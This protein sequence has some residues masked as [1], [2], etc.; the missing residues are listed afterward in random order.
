MITFCIHNQ[1][2]GSGKS[3]VAVN[4]AGF[5][6]RNN[7][8]TLL[9][10]LDPQG[11][12]GVW[13]LGPN[14]QREYGGTKAIFDLNRNEVD[15]RPVGFSDNFFICPAHYDL[16]YVDRYLWAESVL[17][18][19]ALRRDFSD[20]HRFL[21]RNALSKLKGIDVVILDTP[22]DHLSTQVD[23][24]MFAA[25]YLIVPVFAR[26]LGDLRSLPVVADLM[27]MVNT[28]GHNI[29]FLGAVFNGVRNSR[30]STTVVTYA[31]DF[32]MQHHRSSR[33]ET[34][35]RYYAQ[36]EDSTFTEKPLAF[37][38]EKIAASV[39]FNEFYQEVCKKIK[40][41]PINLQHRE[42]TVSKN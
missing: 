27:M 33:F 8:K 3:F 23:N 34:Q 5:F 30:G 16:R 36:I 40:L 28:A 6:A 19:G 32:L 11:D 4:L 29:Q 17:S 35:L 7:Y 13:V 9:I 39:N 26:G 1:K 22:P 18:D 20:K 31:G 21:L 24:A 42:P 38:S 12:A 10:D 15:Y 2:G 25:D 37:I 41:S 14:N